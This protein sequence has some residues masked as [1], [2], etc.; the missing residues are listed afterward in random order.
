MVSELT[1]NQ[2]FRVY[3]GRTCDLFE[4]M[5]HPTLRS[6][7]TTLEGYVHSLGHGLG[8]HVHEMPFSGST[9]TE[10]EKLVPGAVFTI[11][12]GLYYPDKGMGVRLED[13]YFVSE[14]GTIEKVVDFPMELVIPV[15]S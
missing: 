4:E 10:Q 3:Q 7:P 9:A 11:E 15:K 5:G 14:Q 1:V 13:T 2:P 12:P 6:N 8:L